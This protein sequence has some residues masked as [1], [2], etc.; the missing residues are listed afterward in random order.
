[1]FYVLTD[2]GDALFKS[3]DRLQAIEVLENI[4]RDDPDAAESLSVAELD[5]DGQILGEP[6]RLATQRPEIWMRTCIDSPDETV[7]LLGALTKSLNSADVARR[8]RSLARAS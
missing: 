4:V 3:N 6:L 7:D 2:H 5:P 1:M 8:R